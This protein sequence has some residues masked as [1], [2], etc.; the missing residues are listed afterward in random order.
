MSPL[1]VGR[2][3]EVLPKSRGERVVLRASTKGAAGEHE[4]RSTGVKGTQ[5]EER[6]H[7]H[8]AEENMV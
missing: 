6:E 8:I 5:K 4:P 3:E 2:E 1:Q 7:T